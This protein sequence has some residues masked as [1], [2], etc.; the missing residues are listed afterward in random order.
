MIDEPEFPRYAPLPVGSM[1]N[2]EDIKAP[3]LL[4]GLSMWPAKELLYR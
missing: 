1:S 4:R 3:G 2:I